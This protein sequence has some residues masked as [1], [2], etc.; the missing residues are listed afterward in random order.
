MAN[1]AAADEEQRK[2]VIADMELMDNRS[3]SIVKDNKLI[4]NVTRRKYELSVLEQKVLCY[5][6]SKIKQEARRKLTKIFS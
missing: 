4:Q 6:L 2:K 5:I 1:L 3:Y